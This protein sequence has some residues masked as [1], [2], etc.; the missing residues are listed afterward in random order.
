MIILPYISDS[1][2]TF[3]STKVPESPGVYK[4]CRHGTA[5]TAVGTAVGTLS[6]KYMRY[7]SV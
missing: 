2:F 4:T 1:Q 6:L 3:V 7:S 5:G